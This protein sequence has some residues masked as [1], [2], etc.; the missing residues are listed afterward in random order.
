MN[1]LFKFILN[2]GFAWLTLLICAFL[3]SKYLLRKKIQSASG[4]TLEKW[5]KVNGV[6]KPLHDVLGFV[7]VAVGL[8]HGLNSPKT[9]LSLHFGSVSWLILLLFACSW[10]IK[11]NFY[12]Y[13]LKIHR[14]LAVLIVLTII[15]H[16]VD[17]GG[18][19]IFK[20]WQSVHYMQD[21][22][23][24]MSGDQPYSRKWLSP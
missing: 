2:Y 22:G 17:V 4:E 10:L 6:I 3:C 24:D 20:A 13:W 9:V 21:I 15:G 8:I 11:K 5:L 23:V 14:V 19:H 1:M 16:I 12:P 7:V 18:I